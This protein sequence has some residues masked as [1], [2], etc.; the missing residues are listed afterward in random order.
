VAVMI[1]SQRRTFGRTATTPAAAGVLAFLVTMGGLTAWAGEPHL[2]FIQGLRSRGYHDIA[3]EYIA[4]LSQRSDVDPEIVQVLPFERAVTL[5]DGAK[6]NPDARSRREQLD[7]AQAA[8]EQFVQGAGSHPL[9]GEANSQRAT[10]LQERALVELWEADDP[11][12][13]QSR[14]AYQQRARE[15]LLKAREFFQQA[16]TKHEA[17]FRAFPTSI[18]EDDTKTRAER[19]KAEIKYLQALLDLAESTYWEAQTYDAGTAERTRLLEQAVAAFDDIHT[20]FRS[21]IVGLLARLWQGKCFEEMGMLGEALGIYNEMLKHDGTSESLMELKARAQ[22]F[23]LICLNHESRHDYQVV[24]AEATN[25]KN[26]AG[27][28]AFTEAGYGI[29]YELA[30]ALE[31][32]GSQRDLSE[33][34]R[35]RWLSQAMATVEPI[36][37]SAGRFRAPALGMNRRLAIALGRSEQDP[38]SFNDAFGAGNRFAEEAGKLVSQQEQY[39]VERKPREVEATQTTLAPMAAE[40]TRM[41]ELALK[42]ADEDTDAQNVAIARLQLANGYFLQRK[43]YEAAAAAEYTAEHLD[44]Q[45][46]LIARNAAYTGLAAWQNAYNDLG[47]ND[48]EFER[49]QLVA[50]A[51][52]I[53]TRW[54]A[55]PEATDARD[56]IAKMFYNEGDATQAAEWWAKV[57]TAAEDYPGAQIKAGQAYWLA[58]GEEL[59]K[60]PEQRVA[61][62][63][64]EQWK[65]AAEQH[66]VTGINA[67]QSKLPATEPTP[68]DLAL[69]KLSLAQIR[70]VNGVYTTTGDLP[71]ALEILTTGPHAVLDATAVPPGEARPK[72]KDNIRSAKMTSFAYQ[73][74]L[75]TYIALRNLEAASEARDKLESVAEQDDSESLTNVYVVFGQELQKEM[76]QLRASGQTTRLNDVRAGFEEF[77]NSISNRTQGQTFGSLLWIGETY[78][79]LAEGSSDDPAKE[80]EFFGKASATYDRMSQRVAEPGFLPEQANEA[81]IYVRLA[82]CLKRQKKFDEA[83]H[84]MLKAVEKNPQA[85]NVQFAAAMLFRD[86]GAAQ[87]S[88]A[89]KL[90]T[91]INGDSKKVWGWNQ[92]ARKLQQA[93]MASQRDERVEQMHYD[94]RYRQAECIRLYAQQQEATKQI[95]FLKQAKGGIEAF[96]RIAGS[97][98]PAEF[99]R[100]DGL[101]REICDDLGEPDAS[102]EKAIVR[103]SATVAPAAAAS[104]ST[105]ASAPV[106]AT[107]S[108]PAAPPPAKHTNFGLVLLLLVLVVAGSI[109]LFVLS[110]RNDRKKRKRKRSGGRSTAKAK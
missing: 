63:K 104:A 5:L 56:A 82:D 3:L 36:G 38:R 15:L 53:V 96:A 26:E 86:W 92:L 108:A 88:N 89:D 22:W 8:F 57:P 46:D 52:S 40:M 69:G 11:A 73:Q 32:L 64:L 9:V 95:E 98:P 66:L 45:F 34:D 55:S 29:Q 31:M 106:A 76:E 35:K 49:L 74:L 61:A 105:P 18:P 91:A 103:A 20:R 24:V 19:D 16:L 48:R 23:R 109:G 10:I 54:P 77:L 14:P 87:A 94:A 43:Y 85:P 90:M 12:N 21:Q 102:L 25:W 97:L 13:V 47:D 100:F 110:V 72:D 79:S 107:T 83:Y 37:K 27:R 93:L 70:N 71:G 99:A 75:R 2:E 17:A 65:A 30:R 39:R 7:A 60:E 6:N 62:D 41:F 44:A 84:E 50:C 58:Y 51:D 4:E 68:N 80:T 78:T 59:S 1:D 81:V 33:G 42:L 101:Y 67:W 28:R